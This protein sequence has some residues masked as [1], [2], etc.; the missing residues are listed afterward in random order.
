MIPPH[1]FGDLLQVRPK[2]GARNLFPGWRV[3]WV[4][5]NVNPAGKRFA[6]GGFRGRRGAARESRGLRSS[7]RSA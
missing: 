6:G 1:V 2:R 5:T 4:H 7:L 3:F